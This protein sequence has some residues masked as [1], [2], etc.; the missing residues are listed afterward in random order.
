MEIIRPQNQMFRDM[1]NT[2][3]EMIVGAAMN[4]IREISGKLPAQKELKKHLGMVTHD[5]DEVMDITWKKRTILVV[6]A[7]EVVV[8]RGGVKVHRK[9]EEVWKRIGKGGH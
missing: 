6:H 8:F 2:H 5:H 3:A 7:P 4:A 1:E 9:I